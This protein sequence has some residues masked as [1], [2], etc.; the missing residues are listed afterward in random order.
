MN[1]STGENRH[2]PAR[3]A[4]EEKRKAILQTALGAFA[5]NGFIKTTISDM[6]SEV[7]IAEATIYEYF[8]NKEEILFTLMGAFFTEL[9]ESLDAHFL[10]VEGVI[11]RFRKWL[12]HHLYFLQEHPEYARLYILET[13][14]NPRFRE[15]RAHDLCE[16][17]RLRLLDLFTAGIREGCFDRRL[18]PELCVSMVFGTVNHMV[19]SK[20]VLR[21]PLDLI[22][23]AEPLYTLFINAVDERNYSSEGATWAETGKR[24]EILE[25]ALAEFHERG[26]QQATISMIARRAGITEPTIYEYFK[27]KQDLLYSIP[28]AAMHGY[29]DTLDGSLR[30][31]GN[32]LHEL[33][34][35]IL[36]QMRSMRDAPTY[37]SVLIMELR[38]DTGF[39][40][41]K[42]YE[43]MREYSSRFVGIIRKGMELG[44]FRKDLDIT[45]ARDLYFGTLDE[46]TLNLLMKGA[47]YRMVES[48]EMLYDLIWHALKVPESPA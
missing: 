15:S 27:N 30:R 43:L 6:A 23:R 11:S 38:S 48:S 47:G 2:K 26:Y 3:P 42:G 44:F 1:G 37:Y 7:G 13:W 41:S 10:G 34:N 19:L 4:Q 14:N 46:L 8:A 9:Q 25:A 21:K 16:Q 35:F 17:Y 45:A 12:W 22:G 28:E 31:L 5:R 36:H 29:L 39:Y 32:P 24:R 18:N 20:V 40:S 33:Y